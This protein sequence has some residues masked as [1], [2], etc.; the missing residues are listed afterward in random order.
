ML[1]EVSAFALE[2]LDNSSTI[3]SYGLW[4]NREEKFE[5]KAKSLQKTSFSAQFA[6]C[7]INPCTRLVNNIIYATLILLGI[8]ILIFD[9][10]FSAGFT[11]GALSSFLAYAY[12]YMAPFNQVAMSYSPPWPPIGYAKRSI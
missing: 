12:Q 5:E 7:L 1:G 6:A 3:E 8:V 4:E 9:T 10:P 11:V 2:S